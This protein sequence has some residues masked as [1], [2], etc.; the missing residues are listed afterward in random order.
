MVLGTFLHTLGKFEDREYGNAVFPPE[1]AAATAYRSI[2]S[3]GAF[4][5]ALDLKPLPKVM[6]PPLVLGCIT[7]AYEAWKRKR[8]MS[9]CAFPEG[10]EEAPLRTGDGDGLVGCSLELKTSITIYR[11]SQLERYI[12]D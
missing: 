2:V 4:R 11:R 12:L 10:S 5:L 9:Y 6:R 1:S 8:S 7:L 3:E